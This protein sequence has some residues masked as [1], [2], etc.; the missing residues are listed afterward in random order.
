MREGGESARAGRRKMRKDFTTRK[1]FHKN[2]VLGCSGL[3]ELELTART[4]TR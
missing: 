3:K 4:M 2:E 1:C